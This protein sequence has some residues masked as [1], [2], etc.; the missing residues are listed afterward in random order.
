MTAQHVEHVQTT[1]Q[2]VAPQAEAVAS[3]FYNRLFEL[4]PSLRPLFRGDLKEQGRKLMTMLQ[5]VVKGLARPE[6]LLPAVEALGR[7]HATYGV[8]PSHYDTVGAALLWTLAQ[9]LGDGFTPEVEAAWTAAYG[10]LA[11]VMI[12]AAAAPPAAAA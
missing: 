3:L 7:R 1:F 5:V 9:G 4:D 10:L 6:Q 2:Q 12:D 11:G 8:A